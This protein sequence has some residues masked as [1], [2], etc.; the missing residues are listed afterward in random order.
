MNI[1]ETTVAWFADPTHWEGPN[2]IPVRLFEH[3][4]LSAASML[5]AVL[6]ALPVGF[7]I[8]HT[9]RG[10]P[11]AVGLA[12][13][14]RAVPTLAAI[15]ILLPVTSAIDPQNGFRVYPTVIAM[16]LLASPPILV[17]AYVGISGVD[18][19]L[20]EAAR[21]M[22][23]RER[24]LLTK[25]EIPLSIAVVVAGVRSAAVQVIA[26][27]TLGAIFGFGGLGRFL[28]DGIANQDPGE[29]Y[30]GVVLVGALALSSEGLFAL[31]QRLITSPGLRAKADRARPISTEELS[32]ATE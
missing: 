31:L 7:L 1:I 5:I 27:A 23:M 12:N 25:V 11:F 15:T 26:T 13:L 32:V 22:G 24:Q 10:V 18:R 6:I 9:G 4:S 16:V 30:G 20:V 14:G 2:G 17:N 3:V 29:I 19:D 21:G 28:V 8:G